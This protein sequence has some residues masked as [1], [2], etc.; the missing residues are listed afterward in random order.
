MY[1]WSQ[2][3]SNEIRW[4][5]CKKHSLLVFAVNLF[6]F[7]PALLSFLLF[8]S[9]LLFSFPFRSFPFFSSFLFFSFLFFETGFRCV[10]LAVLDLQFCRP[11]WPQTH[12]ASKVLGVK[13]CAITARL[14][15]NLYDK[16]I[17]SLP[18]CDGH[19]W[20][21]TW[22]HL[23]LTKTKHLGTLLRNGFWSGRSPF[24]CLLCRLVWRT[25]RK[26]AFV[27]SCS[28]SPWKS[29]PSL[30]A[31]ACYFVASSLSHSLSPCFYLLSLDRRER[32]GEEGGRS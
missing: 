16:K 8:F 12:S 4:Y 19:S 5:L 3:C 9:F 21:S 14:L 6:L 27:A 22:L 18:Y 13:A 10:S 2:G 11:G 26:G 23:E 32:T 29:T 25:W 1:I 31:G 15:C 7:L 28:C 20:L 17:N 30:A 24:S